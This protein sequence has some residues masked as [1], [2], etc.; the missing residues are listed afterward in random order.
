MRGTSPVTYLPTYLSA[1]NTAHCDHRKT[2]PKPLTPPL[3]PALIPIDNPRRGERTALSRRGGVPLAHRQPK[4][5]A[6]KQANKA[7]P[8]SSPAQP[9]ALVCFLFSFFFS[10]FLCFFFL[11]VCLR[12]IFVLL[13]TYSSFFCSLFV[14]L[15]LPA[16]LLAYVLGCVIW[17][18][19]KGL[20]VT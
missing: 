18:G 2:K 7:P 19:F 9:S 5:Q 8:R 1:G 11:F 15:G 16:C 6:S 13:F 4:K 3:A 12:L 17:G 10:F 20:F 14:L